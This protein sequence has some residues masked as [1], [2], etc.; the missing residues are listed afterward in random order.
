MLLVWLLVTLFF[1]LS[2]SS[3]LNIIT[4]EQCT[5][6]YIYIHTHAYAYVCT[7]HPGTGSLELAA[8]VPQ[9]SARRRLRPGRRLLMADAR[10]RASW[11]DSI[12]RP[13]LYTKSYD[14]QRAQVLVVWFH[15]PNMADYISWG[16]F[17]WVL[18]IIKSP[19]VWF[20][21]SYYIRAPDFWKHPDTDAT[22]P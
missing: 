8:S 11:Q 20:F 7:A 4:L 14:S 19:T 3:S 17:L 16:S 12:P 2:S 10:G 18:I 1:L 22:A 21:A 13:H 9:G 15:T 6:L 5:H